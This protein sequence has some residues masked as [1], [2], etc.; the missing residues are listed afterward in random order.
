M[1]TY[2]KALE[3]SILV[4]DR[5]MADSNLRYVVALMAIVASCMTLGCSSNAQ[6]ADLTA[7]GASAQISQSWS[8]D[9]LNHFAITFH[10]DDVIEC[11]VK[12][13]LWKLVETTDRGYTRTAY[14]LSD[15]GNKGLFAIDLKASGKAHE[16]TLRG[17]YRFE[18]ISIAPGTDPDTRKVEFHWEIDW[19][20]APAELKVCLPKFELAG[21]E[22]GLFKLYG[23][24]WRFVSYSKPEDSPAAQ[25]AAP[26]VDKLP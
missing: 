13:D 5:E 4:V 25:A 21:Y 6:L 11:G 18:I 23:Q 9:E 3:R 1:T 12:N 20:K 10:S 8:H 2:A 7:R 26:A 15:K 19:N 16:I 22:V 14:Q 17:P 24:E